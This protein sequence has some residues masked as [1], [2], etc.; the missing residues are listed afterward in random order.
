M[1]VRISLASLTFIKATGDASTGSALKQKAKG[2]RQKAKGK[3]QKTKGK[4]QK[5]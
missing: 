2:K 3:R 5:L 1:L 4:R